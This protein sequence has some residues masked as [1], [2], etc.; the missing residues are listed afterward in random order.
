VGEGRRGDAEIGEVWGELGDKG[1]RRHGDT[2]TKGWEEGL[3]T[4]LLNS[5]MGVGVVLL[6][7]VRTKNPYH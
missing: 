7:G 3:M 2:E 6:I 4:E 5:C 1:T